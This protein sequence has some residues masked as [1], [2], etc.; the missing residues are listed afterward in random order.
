MHGPARMRSL[1]AEMMARGAGTMV[2]ARDSGNVLVAA[3]TL[4]WDTQAM[5]YLFGTRRPDMSE[6]GAT[7]M[8]IWKGIQDA[9]ERGLIFDLDGVISPGM[10]QFLAGFGGTLTQRLRVQ[11]VNRRFRLINAMRHL[12][13]GNID[14]HTRRATE[15]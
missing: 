8:L 2:G 6:N 1:L 7:S 14:V 5:Y 4:V 9:C 12:L 3:V 10:L 11:N 15:E 13:R